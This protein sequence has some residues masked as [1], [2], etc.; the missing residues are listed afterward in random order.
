MGSM[1]PHI[2][3][4]RSAA[5]MCR[6]GL[7]CERDCTSMMRGL[8]SQRISLGL[9]HSERRRSY[10]GA[11]CDCVQ[12]AHSGDTWSADVDEDDSY[13]RDNTICDYKYDRDNATIFDYDK[14]D[15]DDKYYG[16]DHYD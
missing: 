13:D 1:G 10:A 6:D 7:K 5:T 2:V 8:F 11:S 9:A 3:A 12:D 16:G 15:R 4:P 14:Y